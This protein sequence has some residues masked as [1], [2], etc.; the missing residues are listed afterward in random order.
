MRRGL[1][2]LTII[3]STGLMLFSACS[4][5]PSS[6]GGDPY[7]DSSSGKDVKLSDV[8]IKDV[9]TDVTDAS[10]D[11]SK[12]TDG[13][14]VYKDGEIPD[15]TEP[16]GEVP[17]TDYTD[18]GTDVSKD[19]VVDQLYVEITPESVTLQ[20][21]VGQQKFEATVFNSKVTTDVTFE[22]V[23]DPGDGSYG[24]ISSSGLYK[25]P[26]E[27]P[28][29]PNITVRVR[30][31]E[32]N[33]VYAD[34]SVFILPAIKVT[35]SPKTAIVHNNMTQQFSALV[36][37]TNDTTVIWEVL[38]GAQNG[39]IDNT[40]FYTAPPDVPNPEEVQIRATSAV[41][42]SKYDT[43]VVTVA[44]PI[45]VNILPSSAIINVGKTKQFTALV[46]NAHQTNAVIWSIEKDPR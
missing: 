36:E 3:L 27:Q 17:D 41:D 16:D 35:V 34:A 2:N 32:D 39:T 25:A 38:G 40:G 22:I 4:D 24:T 28:A 42:N 8:I 19:A 26:P 11:A 12:D 10:K 29:N 37:N 23:G 7:E 44:L 30:C 31:V 6:G 46:K 15:G 45:E 43:A 14:D 5:S 1:C 13:S 18:G 9:I 33:S 21:N 20:A